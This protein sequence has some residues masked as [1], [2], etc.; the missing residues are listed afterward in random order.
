MIKLVQFSKGKY[1]YVVLHK[2]QME[3]S[4]VMRY[5]SPKTQKQALSRS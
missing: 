4:L 5:C 1:T 2:K 3:T